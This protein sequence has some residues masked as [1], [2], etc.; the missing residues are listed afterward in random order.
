MRRDGITSEQA[1][2]RDLRDIEGTWRKDR[3]F[4]RALA[5]QDAIDP[6]MWQ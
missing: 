3:A 1:P 6:E 4:D 2:Q 5:A